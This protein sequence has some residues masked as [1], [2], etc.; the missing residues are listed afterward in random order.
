MENREP[1]VQTLDGEK[2]DLS[3]GQEKG[4]GAGSRR[5]QDTAGDEASVRGG[6]SPAGPCRSRTVGVRSLGL[7]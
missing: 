5:A 7:F 2:L 3:K 6:P 4:P 1:A